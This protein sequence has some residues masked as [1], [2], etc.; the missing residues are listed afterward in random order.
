VNLKSPA[1]EDLLKELKVLEDREKLLMDDLMVNNK[2][3]EVQ[4]IKKS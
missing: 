2:V 3:K 1:D 4:D